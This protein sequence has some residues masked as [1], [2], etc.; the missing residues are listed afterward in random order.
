[1]YGITH[2]VK[3]YNKGETYSNLNT[4]HMQKIT[5][6]KHAGNIKVSVHITSQHSKQCRDLQKTEFAQTT[7]QNIC[8]NLFAKQYENQRAEDKKKTVL[9]VHVWEDQTYMAK[10]FGQ[11]R[12]NFACRL[13]LA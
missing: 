2:M 6:L 8:R 4:S 10:R 13:P 3:Y 5:H 11:F 7:L 12:S 9:R 1:M